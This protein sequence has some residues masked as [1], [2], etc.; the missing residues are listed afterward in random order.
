MSPIIVNILLIVI[1][2]QGI[3][4]LIAIQLLP[5]KNKQANKM[6]SIILLIASIILITRIATAY[7]TNTLFWRLGALIDM[8]I[9]VFGPL[10]YCYIRRLIF[11]EGKTYQLKFT[12]F[13]PLLIYSGYFLWLLTQTKESYKALYMSNK[14]FIPFLT[15]EL[16]GILLILFY[17][18]KSFQLLTLYKKQKEEQYA[19]DQKIN[20][21][22]Y[23]ILISLTIFTVL[24][25]ISFVSSYFFY[26]YYVYLN[27]NLMWISIGGLFYVIGFYSLTQP[28]IFRVE[29]SQPKINVPDRLSKS[30]IN[31]LKRKLDIELKEKKIYL[32]STISL[33]ALSKTLGTTTNNLSWLLNKVYQKN[34]Y[35]FINEYRIKAFLELIKENEHI[36]STLFALAI[37]VG[38]NSKSTFNKSFKVVCGTTPSEYI[39]KNYNN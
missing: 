3:F 31:E 6:L 28:E 27:Y 23:C 18:I 16:S 37:D 9:Y 1:L 25:F 7:Y 12:H 24:W 4:L 39:K 19:T 11:K 30:E 20:K 10:L 5:N 33:V 17:V 13:I 34:F 8:T 36:K 32:K 29:V 35:E 22:V 38:F 14:L 21:F 26:K 15:I 2:S